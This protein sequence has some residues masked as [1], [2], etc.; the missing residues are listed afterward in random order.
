[1]KFLILLSVVAFASSSPVAQ[2]ESVMRLFLGNIVSCVN[3]DLGLCLKEQ[4]LK[5]TERLGSVRQLKLAEGVTI[6]NNV[7]KDGK[8]LDLS[9]EPE[10]RK[11]QV[12]ERLWQSTSDLLKN[13]DLELSFNAPVGDD[14][15][16]RALDDVEEGRGKKKEMKKK[17]KMLVPLLL[18]A[19]AK[20]IALV[21]FS[22]LVIAAS[23]FKLAVLAKI[24]FIAK[25]IAA[26]KLLLARKHQEEE[27]GWVPHHEEHH[28]H[29]HGWE[30]GWSRSRNEANNLAYSAYSK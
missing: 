5:V 25:A 10:E 18:L 4:A 3:S 17:L 21:V 28:D 1:M 15:E 29:G 2:D 7:P 30:G 24:A 20:A 6:L 22:L 23:L 11:K 16:S 9:A 19:K 27:H 12:S 26:L 14:D 8:S 13:S